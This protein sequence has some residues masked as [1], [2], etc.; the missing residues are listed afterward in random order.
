[1]GPEPLNKPPVEQEKRIVISNH[2]IKHLLPH[3]TLLVHA[4]PHSQI[5]KRQCRSRSNA[6]GVALEGHLLIGYVI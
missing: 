3:S 5:D 4:L 1:M 2:E 6:I